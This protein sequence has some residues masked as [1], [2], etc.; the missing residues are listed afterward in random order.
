MTSY[1][2]TALFVYA[3]SLQ[4]ACSRNPATGEVQTRLMSE[5]QEVALGQTEH[6]NILATEVTLEDSVLSAYVSDVGRRLAAVSERPALPWTFTVLDDDVVN[7][8]AMPGGF[9]Y[10]TRG[11]LTYLTS[12]AE[13]AGVLGHEI[14]LV[15][16]RHSVVDLRR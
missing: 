2:S 15:T 8:M 5:A 3:A 10:V 6:A 1:W 13:L 4:F 11:I 7:A 12:E 14:V 9:V 16:A